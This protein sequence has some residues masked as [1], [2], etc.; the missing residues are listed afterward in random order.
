MKRRYSFKPDWVTEPGEHLLETLQE[1]SLS[2]HEF[3]Q[4]TGYSP[5]HVQRLLSGQARIRLHT[6]RRLAIGT[7]VP[8][9][10]W[11]NLEANYQSRKRRLAQR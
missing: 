7:G 5:G 9:S 10:L 8:A 4:R 1:L 2:P 6:A 11:I 3:A